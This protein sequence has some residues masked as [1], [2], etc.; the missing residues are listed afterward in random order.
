MFIFSPFSRKE[1]FDPS[2]HRGKRY[3]RMSWTGWVKRMWG[4]KL[5]VLVTR[6]TMAKWQNP[7][8]RM[9]V[10]WASSMG[11]HPTKKALW[12]RKKG[13]FK[14]NQRWGYTNLIKH[15]GVISTRK[16]QMVTC[17]N[18]VWTH[19]SP[20]LFWPQKVGSLPPEQNRKDPF[21]VVSRLG[22]T[23]VTVFGPLRLSH[24]HLSWHV[25]A[26]S[27]CFPF[28]P[29]W[30]GCH[31]PHHQGGFDGPQCLERWLMND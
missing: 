18:W 7:A 29:R 28:A 21:C 1:G 6:Q 10:L 8:G 2:K 22:F 27:C 16:M 13:G 5:G 17:R 31:S 25:M 15:G 24:Y 30:A 12:R 3:F 20:T 11:I 23:M 19:V 26:S 14:Y 9:G 4:R